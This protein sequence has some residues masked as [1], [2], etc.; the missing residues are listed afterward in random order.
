MPDEVGGQPFPD[1][2]EPDDRDDRAADDAFASLVL[3]E[4]FVRTASVHEPS[5]EERMLAA[6]RAR[7]EAEAQQLFEEGLAQRH[8]D[9]YDRGP[10]G[11]YVYGDPDDARRFAREDPEYAEYAWERENR[12]PF[13]REPIRWQRPVA[14]VLA[15]VM[16]VGMVAMAFAAVYRG[17]GGEPDESVP[18]PATTEVDVT[19]NA[20]PGALP[21]VSADTGTP[22]ISS[23]AAE[24]DNG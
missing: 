15:V 21:S 16:G 17:S 2:E 23:A 11:G 14:W 13:A 19:V 6:A 3:D 22:T 5:A 24:P 18:P 8:P 1:G 20:P 10:V 12:A 4:E 9:E 7:A